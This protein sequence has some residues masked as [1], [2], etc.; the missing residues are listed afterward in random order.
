MGSIVIATIQIRIQNKPNMKCV[1]IIC[2]FLCFVQG[3][4]ILPELEETER[5]AFQMCDSDRMI[6]LTWREVE[7]CEV[8]FADYLEEQDIPIPS[9]E[10]FEAADLNADG[11]LMFEEW[12]EWV[13]EQEEEMQDEGEEESTEDTEETNEEV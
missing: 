10:D 6:G 1:I 4:Q 11:T 7:K 3:M 9:K 8:R 13:K 12:E 2:G 5:K